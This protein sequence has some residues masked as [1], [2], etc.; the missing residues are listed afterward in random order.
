M[1]LT[2]TEDAFCFEGAVLKQFSSGGELFA[3]MKSF[4]REDGKKRYT[5]QRKVLFH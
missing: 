3:T 2:V 1:K 4:F 5:E